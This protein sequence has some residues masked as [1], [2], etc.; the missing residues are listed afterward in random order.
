V[1]TALGF[2][3]GLGL[4]AIITA[5]LP[6]T[7]AFLP[8]FVLSGTGALLGSLIYRGPKRLLLE[9]KIQQKRLEIEMRQLETQ[10]EINFLLGV[11]RDVPRIE[12]TAVLGRISGLLERSYPT[13]NGITI[14]HEAASPDGKTGDPTPLNLGPGVGRGTSIP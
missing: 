9:W 4:A 13:S 12:K 8:A 10:G 1:L 7:S 6:I 14:E 5:S 2:F 3:G 11:Y